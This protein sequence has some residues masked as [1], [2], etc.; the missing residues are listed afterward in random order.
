MRL[1][2]LLDGEDGFCGSAEGL[3]S[4]ALALSGVSQRFWV[5]GR[6]GLRLVRSKK[7][8]GM[9]PKVVGSI[10]EGCSSGFSLGA[11]AS[12]VPRDVFGLHISYAVVYLYGHEDESGVDLARSFLH[13][14]PVEAG[15]EDV[16]DKEDKDEIED[17]LGLVVKAM[18]E[19]P[20]LAKVVENG[21]LDL[22]PFMADLA[23][24]V[25]RYEALGPS[26]E[27]WWPRTRLRLAGSQSTRPSRVRVGSRSPPCVGLEG[28]T[29]WSR[30]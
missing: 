12:L 11:A 5:W 9:R 4:F 20:V 16:G 27:G 30:W 7:N 28:E 3:S 1:N 23:E 22:P 17:G 19:A 15:Q 18:I 29:G 2:G 14:Q 8:T 25:R 10:C 21:V 6:R 24:L 26:A 13:V